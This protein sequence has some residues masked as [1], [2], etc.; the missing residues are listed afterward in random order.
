MDTNV[1]RNK[2]VKKS[3]QRQIWGPN[4]SDAAILLI[5]LKK[6]VAGFSETSVSTKLEGVKARKTALPSLRNFKSHEW[7]IFTWASP[8]GMTH[9]SSAVTNKTST[10]RRPPLKETSFPHS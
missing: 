9:S 6:E 2:P 7:D 4:K 3:G 8:A 5:P 1:E 10:Q